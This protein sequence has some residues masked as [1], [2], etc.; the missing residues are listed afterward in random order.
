[1]PEGRARS[2]RNAEDHRENESSHRC[3]PSLRHLPG[4]GRSRVAAI[5]QSLVPARCRRNVSTAACI[6]ARSAFKRSGTE[7]IS[8][9]S[10]TVS[11]AVLDCI[12]HQ[13]PEIAVSSNEHK[14][15]LRN[16]AS[17][18]PLP[19]NSRI[20]PRPPAGNGRRLRSI[21]A[22]SPLASRLAS[23]VSTSQRSA[24]TIGS[25]AGISCPLIG[26][27]NAPPRDRLF[28]G[29]LRR[30]RSGHRCQSEDHLALISGQCL[31][32]FANGANECE[33]HI[34]PELFDLP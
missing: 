22:V 14:P 23:F 1:M 7:A 34:G 21:R 25:S 16:V 5:D 24:R 17:I 31:G 9:S 28:G 15:T 33:P 12:P 6:L 27:P 19:S 8:M 18:S 32:G 13:T 20:A 29:R 10:P 2:N 11:P 3:Y 26:R 30:S 4:T